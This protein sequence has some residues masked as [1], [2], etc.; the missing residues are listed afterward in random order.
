MEVGSLPYLLARCRKAR[1]VVCRSRP[2]VKCNFNCRSMPSA[3]SEVHGSV[4]GRGNPQ[5]P[6]Q[7]A[8]F[9]IAGLI[10]RAFG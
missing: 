9:T 1:P 8:N 6:W 5:L 7:A 3:P 10:I 2:F 4:G